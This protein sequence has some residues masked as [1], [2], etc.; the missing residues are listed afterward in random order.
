MG[1]AFATFDPASVRVRAPRPL[2][3]ILDRFLDWLVEVDGGQAGQP[4]GS[5]DG[6][7]IDDFW[8]DYGSDLSDYVTVFLVLGDGS[9][10]A[11]WHDVDAD[12]D[13]RPVV[14]IGSEGQLGVLGATTAHFLMKLATGRELDPIDL[15]PPHEL[16][17]FRSQL[18]AWLRKNTDDVGRPLDEL[19]ASDAR[20]GHSDLNKW[21]EQ[22][23]AAARARARADPAVNELHRRFDTLVDE[24]KLGVV[25]PWRPLTFAVACVGQHFESWRRGEGPRP[26][27][28]GF[29][30]ELEPVARDYR[31][32]RALTVPGRGAWFGATFRRYP[33]GWATPACTFDL[34][35]RLSG[36]D[37]AVGTPVAQRPTRVVGAAAYREDLEAFPRSPRW[38]PDW[39]V[40][41]IR[42]G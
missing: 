5:L 22:K 15:P 12:L 10:I 21:F 24:E 14:L 7:W 36:G 13:R 28:A 2:P 29:V 38:M 6:D 1:R 20:G 42:S 40:E 18:G 8:I 33:D 37:G 9:R 30:A 4:F 27:P 19:A 31:R 34:P 25:Q 3:A 39:L 16:E 35:P 23:A 11:V 17:P 41:I 26:L 32:S